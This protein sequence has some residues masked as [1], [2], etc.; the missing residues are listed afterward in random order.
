MSQ[1]NLEIAQR[2]IAFMNRGDDDGF[3]ALMAE[4]VEYVP[5]SESPL[6]GREQVLQYVRSWSEAFDR[7][8][9]ESSQLLDVGHYVVISGRVVGRGRGS[10]VE[11]W[12]DDA[13]VLRFRDGEVIECCEYATRAEA[14]EAVGLPE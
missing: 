7:F 4:D 3:V 14:L 10:G 11:V 6:Q 1:E 2:G 5:H 9:W 8:E 12:S 13:W